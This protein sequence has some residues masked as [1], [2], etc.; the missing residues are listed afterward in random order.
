MVAKP[1]RDDDKTTDS[2]PATPSRAGG[3]VASRS[4]LPALGAVEAEEEQLTEELN[5]VEAERQALSQ[6]TSSMAESPRSKLDLP[7]ILQTSSPHKSV[8]SL[9]PVLEKPDGGKKRSDFDD[10]SI[11]ARLQK[12]SRTTQ[13]VW[14]HKEC[15]VCKAW[16]S[17]LD[18]VCTAR[19]RKV[20]FK[21]CLTIVCP[22]TGG[23]F[24][25][26]RWCYAPN[27]KGAV[28][29]VC[30]Y[31]CRTLEVDIEVMCSF[32]E[33]KEKIKDDAYKKKFRYSLGQV[34]E[35]AIQTGGKVTSTTF[36]TVKM[37]KK[38]RFTHKRKGR[39][40]TVAKFL[41]RKGYKPPAK[42]ILTKKNKRGEIVEYV[43]I[44]NDSDSS[45]WDIEEDSEI[46]I[47][48]CETLETDE[49]ALREGHVDQRY[50]DICKEQFKSESSKGT[51]LSKK[52]VDEM[53]KKTEAEVA[54]KKIKS[55]ETDQDKDKDEQQDE[56]ERVDES[57]TM[58]HS[59][60]H[61]NGGIRNVKIWLRPSQA[62]TFLISSKESMNHS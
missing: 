17:D 62:H 52:S 3:D 14:V 15:N 36:A 40:I 33:A 27:A 23:V 41:K 2:E 24:F 19:H 4:G 9:S 61:C 54:A 10:K 29:N 6:A 55:G 32:G 42:E 50:A 12:M 8:A 1:V 38:Q 46:E 51:R 31:C 56:K 13:K 28:G 49:F 47:E 26:R 18:P 48:K 57:E 60:V 16:S 7:S 59:A 34:E 5:Q 44:W 35:M 20:A 30:W 43:H 39:A 37:K 22:Q 25:G 58:A 45:E 21:E 53:E 11:S